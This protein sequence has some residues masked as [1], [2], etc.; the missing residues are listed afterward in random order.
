MKK[1]WIL[2]TLVSLVI[3]SPSLSASVDK[4]VHKEFLALEKLAKKNDKQKFYLALKQS[5]HPLSPYAEATF[6]ENYPKL[7][8]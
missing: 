5:S 3:S 7:S 8:N 6:L 4:T 1:S 2:T